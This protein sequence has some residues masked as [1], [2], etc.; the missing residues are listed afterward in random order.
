MRDT[1]STDV[2]SQSFL[3]LASVSC[4]FSSPASYLANTTENATNGPTTTKVNK[5]NKIRVNTTRRT[6]WNH[7]NWQSRENVKQAKENL[8]SE[9]QNKLNLLLFTLTNVFEGGQLLIAKFI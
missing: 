7:N 4:P 2:T 9:M 1:V 5:K 6:W 8:R 3:R